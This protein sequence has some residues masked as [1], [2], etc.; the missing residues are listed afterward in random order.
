MRSEIVREVN[1]EPPQPAKQSY[2][3]RWKV[4]EGR[5]VALD[6]VNGAVSGFYRDILSKVKQLLAQQPQTVFERDLRH[7][8]TDDAFTMHAFISNS[9]YICL[10][11]A[12]N[13]EYN[14][15]YAFNNCPFEAHVREWLSVYPV[16]DRSREIA[17][18][19]DFSIFFKGVQAYQ[20]KK[21]TYLLQA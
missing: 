10:E 8:N 4:A 13:Y 19:P 17:L 1:S 18:Q 15:E 20:P 2:A 7:D 6:R 16:A 21:F 3:K 12:Y 11:C 9:I 5:S 14:I